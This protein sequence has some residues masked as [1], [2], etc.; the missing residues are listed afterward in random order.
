V[1]GN[2]GVIGELETG[3]RTREAGKNQPGHYRKER[4]AGEDFYRRDQMS[5][6][7]LRMHVAIANRRQCLD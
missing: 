7:S 6:I 2:H 4:H 3:A 1:V 5:V